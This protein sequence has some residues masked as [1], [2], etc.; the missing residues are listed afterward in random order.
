MAFSASEAPSYQQSAKFTYDVYRTSREAPIGNLFLVFLRTDES[1][2]RPPG[3]NQPDP[4][5]ET[6][7]EEK[8]LHA[9]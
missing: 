8:M 2:R 7:A 3:Y 6:P 9:W 5:G 1:F 4:G